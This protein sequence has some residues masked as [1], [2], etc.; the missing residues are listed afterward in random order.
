MKTLFLLLLPLC[1]IVPGLAQEAYSFASIPP[2]LLKH[3][4]SVVRQ[5]DLKFQVLNKGEGL[6]TEHKVITIIN[7]QAADELDQVFWYD[8]IRK[9]EEIEGSVY[10]ANGKLVRKIKKKDILDQKPF[11]HQ[12]V[13]DTRAKLLQFPRLAFPFTIEYTVVSHLNGLMFYPVF[14]PQKNTVQSV[15]SASFQLV[16]P[17]D[18]K[19]RYLEFNVLPGQKTGALHWQFQNIPAFEPELFLPLG[20]TNLPKVMTA[21][22]LFRL[23]GFDG[24]MSSWESY[25]KF[26]GTLNAEKAKLPAE[27]VAKLQQLTADCPDITCKAKRVYEFLQKNTRYYYVG[28][29]IGGWQPMPANDVDKFKYSDCK[30]LSNYTMAMLQAVGVPAYYALIRA[31]A[32]EQ[33]VQI[34]EF[35]SPW[36]NHATL[37]IPTSGE[38]IWL[39]CTSQTQSFGFLSDFTDDRLALVIYPEGGKIVQTPGYDETVNTILRESRVTLE[40]D[41]SANLESNVTFRALEQDFAFQLS[42]MPDDQ[43]KKYLYHF[44]NLSDFE[45]NALSFEVKKDIIP[46]VNQKLSLHIPKLASVSGKRLFLPVSFLSGKTEIPAFNLPR[47]HPVQFQSRGKTE[48][49]HLTITIPDGFKIENNLNPV[50][51]QSDFGSFELQIQ[52]QNNQITIHRKLV[53]NNSVQPKEKFD[54]LLTFLKD[55]AKAD[56]AKLVLVH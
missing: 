51:I 47:E 20:Y 12:F 39:E 42:E 11:E 49:D 18:L 15:E 28:L 8:Q 50:S 19:I 52:N 16:A 45:I 23:E 3:A 4:S 26:I 33:N 7:D 6:E 22:T 2:E 44:M 27:T 35:P 14:E 48:E 29:G 24:D 53:L 32:S 1:S 36:F 37:C 30:G 34:E 5:Y 56:Q 31:K 9:I 21:P 46:E 54:A 25:G 17:D 38:M 43:R 13:N 55:I 10:D 40:M 41:G